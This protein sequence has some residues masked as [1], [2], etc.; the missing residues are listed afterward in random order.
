MKIGLAQIN[1][2]PGDLEANSLKMSSFIKR[3]ARAGC[4][5]VLFPEMS[6]TGYVP[7]VIRETAQRWPGAPVDALRQSACDHSVYLIA[8]LSERD[9]SSI[10]NSIAVIS[11]EGEIIAKYRKIHLFSAAPIHEDRCF[12]AGSKIA[13]VQI[14]GFQFGLSICYDLRFPDLYR[15]MALKGADVL[16]NCTAWPAARSSHWDYLSRARAIENQCYF[17]GVDR[18]GADKDFKFNGGSRIVEPYGD[19][20]VQAEAGSEMLVTGE[21]DQKKISSFREAIPAFREAAYKPY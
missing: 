2:V 18:A 3:A 12:T 11:P 10:F 19:I 20:C 5:V 8:G 14:D 16:L 17:I 7:E 6:D 13:I 9:G 4:R 15:A 21:I 1:C